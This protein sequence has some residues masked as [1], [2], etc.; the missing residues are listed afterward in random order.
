MTSADGGGAGQ[1]SA[2]LLAATELISGGAAGD[3]YRGRF[4]DLLRAVRGIRAVRLA[5]ERERPVPPEVFRLPLPPRRGR[6]GERDTLLVE[7]ARMGDRRW[8]G[9]PQRRRLESAL[10]FLAHALAVPVLRDSLSAAPAL[11]MQLNEES[12]FP[13]T[14]HTAQLLGAPG[15]PDRAAGPLTIVDPRD[16]VA[17]LRAFAEVHC[18]LRRS[19][20]A[21]LRVSCRDGGELNLDTLFVDLSRVPGIEGIVVAGHDMTGARADRAAVV[22]LLRRLPHAAFVVAH[23]GTVAAANGQFGELVGTQMRGA[24]EERALWTVAGRCLDRDEA[25]R[26]FV[27]VLGSRRGGSGSR[28][29]AG[30]TLHAERRPLIEAGT[31]YGALWSFEIREERPAAPGS[32]H[33][34]RGRALAA[35]AREI[36]TPATALLSLAQMLAGSR[37]G[38][39][40]QRSAAEVIDRNA[41]RLR[42]LAVDLELFNRLGSGQV[43]PRFTEVDL[44]SLVTEVVAAAGSRDVRSF[45]GRGPRARADPELLRQA[46]GRVLDNAL[47][48][49][50]GGRI[51]VSAGFSGRR[52]EIEISDS[53]IGIPPGD[54]GRVPHPFERGTNAVAA[55]LPGAGLGLA[56]AGELLALQGATVRLASVLGTGTTVSIGLETVPGHR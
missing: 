37:L 27:S 18:G 5:P 52:W 22:E 7:L 47:R 29:G 2:L 12:W 11:V 25:Y 23:D 15:D 32:A 24:A 35:V 16:R 40:E 48:Y 19:A 50:D 55:G 6:P 43:R 36:R 1:V 39:M 10:A 20:R 54:L 45:T 30:R 4:A 49:R 33:D 13:W 51:R 56:I 53:G 31:E 42:D 41:G 14:T 38:A 28:L 34:Q 8:S 46:L 26:R 21:P 17:A 3:E 9:R 44:P